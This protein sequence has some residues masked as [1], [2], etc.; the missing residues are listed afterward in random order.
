MSFVDCSETITAL[1]NLVQF[2]PLAESESDVIA[3]RGAFHSPIG[4]AV[5]E[6]IAASKRVL[7]KK[8]DDV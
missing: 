2:S 3:A 4:Q 7:V 1:A 5:A 6:F 8:Q